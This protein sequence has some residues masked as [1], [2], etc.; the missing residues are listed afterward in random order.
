MARKQ[1]APK[2]KAL[3]GNTL[4]VKRGPDEEGR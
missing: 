4:N 3:N 2:N 1:K